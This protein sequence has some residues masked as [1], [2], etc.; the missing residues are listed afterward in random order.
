[1]SFNGP[2]FIHLQFILA[3]QGMVSQARMKPSGLWFL[4]NI[5]PVSQTGIK[6]SAGLY[7]SFDGKNP[8]S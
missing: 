1:M 5:G 7:F 3:H 8:H 6:N 2:V 4:F